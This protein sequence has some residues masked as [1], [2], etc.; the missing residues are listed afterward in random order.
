MSFKR[1]CTQITHYNHNIAH[2]HCPGPLC[3]LSTLILY[4]CPGQTLICFLFSFFFFHFRV[5]LP[6]LIRSGIAELYGNHMFNF[7][8]HAKPIFK[9][10]CRFTFYQQCLSSRGSTTLLT[11]DIVILLNLVFIVGMRCYISL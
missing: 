3:H 4:L 6:I 5:T 1:V 10:L 7:L 11:I 2:P 8:K 9:L